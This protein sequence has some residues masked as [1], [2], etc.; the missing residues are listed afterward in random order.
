M[1]Y[2]HLHITAAAVQSPHLPPYS[3]SFF[4]SIHNLFLSIHN[5]FLFFHNLFLSFHNLFLFFHNLFLFFH[6]LFLSFHNFF[7]FFHRKDDEAG[8][9]SLQ[10]FLNSS[11]LTAKVSYS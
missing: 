2:P 4:L 9:P 3:T 11:R 8:T 7:L 6:N 1:R 5:L 10:S